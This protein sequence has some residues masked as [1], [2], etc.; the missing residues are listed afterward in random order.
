MGG[1]RGGWEEEEE[2]SG[3]VRMEGGRKGGREMDSELSLTLVS[4]NRSQ[5]D[6]VMKPVSLLESNRRRKFLIS[7][8]MPG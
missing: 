8:D 5:S 4:S 2:Q 1:R 3:R 6:A 7:L